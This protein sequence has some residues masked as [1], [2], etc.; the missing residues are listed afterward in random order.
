MAQ[1]PDGSPPPPRAVCELAH[2]P[3]GGT[4]DEKRHLFGNTNHINTLCLR[5]LFSGKRQF[6]KIQ[7]AGSFGLEQKKT[8]ISSLGPSTEPSTRCFVTSPVSRIAS[9]NIY[10]RPRDVEK[11]TLSLRRMA[12]TRFWRPSQRWLPSCTICFSLLAVSVRF[13]RASRRYCLLTS[14][15]CVSLSCTC[16]WKACATQGSVSAAAAGG[17]LGRGRGSPHQEEVLLA[18]PEPG[19]SLPR[20]SSAP[21]W[22]LCTAPLRNWGRPLSSRLT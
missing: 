18:A 11:V 19:R 15:S 22:L 6:K 9:P 14:S 8:P 13:S 12:V 7:K 5:S 3:S 20:T 2:T 16:R 17:A 4:E 21:L 1:T 10:Q